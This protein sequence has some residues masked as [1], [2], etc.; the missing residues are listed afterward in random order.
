MQDTRRGLIVVNAAPGKSGIAAM[1]A[2]K[3]NH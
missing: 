2:V 3:L 1:G